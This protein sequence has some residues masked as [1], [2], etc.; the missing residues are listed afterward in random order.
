MGKYYDDDDS[1]FDDSFLTDIS[2]SIANQ[3]KRELKRSDSDGY[4]YY[5]GREPGGRSKQDPDYIKDYRNFER[6]ADEYDFDDDYDDIGEIRHYRDERSY[7]ERSR[8]AEQKRSADPKRSSNRKSTVKKSS[9]S[10]RHSGKR[11]E[12]DNFRG[13]EAGGG[14][15]KKGF[16]RRM[17]VW[18][19]VA[20]VILG[21]IAVFLI[22]GAAYY[23]YLLSLV[24]YDKEPSKALDDTTVQA[25]DTGGEKP[26]DVSWDDVNTTYRK[27]EGVLNFLLVGEENVYGDERG[28]TDSI[29][30]VTL[31]EKEGAIKLTSV[32]RDCYVKIPSYG[33]KNYRDNK[34]NASY[35]LGG[36]T[37][38][39]MT[40]EENFDIYIDG[41]AKVDFNG[42][43]QMIDALGGV[44]ITLSAQE[45]SYLN[46]T[47]YISKK[48]YRNVKEG[49]QTLNG[50]QALGYSRVRKVATPE[51]LHDDFGRTA[52]QRKVL[53]SLFEKYK[54]KSLVE[55]MLM[56]P[57]VM[58][59]VTTDLNKTQI[60]S[61][62][63]KLVTIRPTKL[64]TKSIPVD[65]GWSDKTISGVGESL[66]LD[67]NKN[68]D[69]LHRFIFGSTM[70]EKENGTSGND[71]TGGQSQNQKQ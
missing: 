25:N 53:D 30:I 7:K 65:G 23:Y 12:P 31:N 40:V 28:R 14:R 43:E 52:R 37:L 49:K 15:K 41:Y 38:T 39:T 24:K 62:L 19:R 5:S 70:S 55:L 51:G 47:N 48:K 17:P 67:M 9:P 1:D 69:E 46:R 54:S 56:L 61:L 26:E 68:I 45:A 21:V 57:K 34:I 18:G 32:M 59:L 66:V 13:L 4:D 63:T 44:E 50:N 64:Q 60:T 6:R 10:R 58:E 42:F 2:E 16:W 3:V 20:T 11:G 33:G 27:E 35:T 22:A 29:M 8:S 71:S 36:M